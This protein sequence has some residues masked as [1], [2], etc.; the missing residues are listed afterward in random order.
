MASLKREVGIGL[1]WVAFA[2]VGM[3]GIA[4][5]RKLILAR[6]LAPND[7][8]LVAYASLAIGVLQL[9]KE[10]GFG[11]ALIYRRDDVDEAANTIFIAVLVSGCALYGLAWLLA[12][13]V[14]DFFHNPALVAILRVLASTMAISGISQVPLVLL[15]KGMGFRN[16]VIPEL[17]AGVAGSGLS[18]Y[19]AYNWFGVWSIVWGQVATTVLTAILVWFFCP[20][21]PKWQFSWRV[22]RELWD[23]ARHIIGSQILVFFI[24]NIDDAFIGRLRGDAALGTYG[25]A[26]DLSNLPAT[27]LSRI[28]GQVT[29]PA[30]SK[31]QNDLVRLRKAFFQSV[32]YV[33]L[34]AFPIA[35]ITL[36]YAKPFIIVSYGKKWTP[37]ILPLQLLAVYGLARSIAV[38][39]GNVFKVGNKPKWLLY[40]ASWRLAMM[41]LFLYPAIQWKGVVGVAALSAVVA[42]IDFC[43]SIYLTNRV[44][45]ASWRRY[46]KLF[47][48]MLVTAVISALIGHQIYTWIG[49]RIH[50]FITI[51]G[52]GGLALL[53]YGS[54]MYFYDPEIRAL[55]ADVIRIGLEAFHQWKTARGGSSV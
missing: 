54:V 29:F 21:R 41:A 43:I 12:P 9:F 37:A 33:S 36:V 52:T 1:L 47:L 31:V 38:N 2:T 4:L 17:I 32:K 10:L 26:Y 25:L 16:K 13:V 6:W 35:I 34:A 39:M 3:K 30:F 5:L 45:H 40:I 22:A 53:L 19:L 46:A 44:L 50:P 55:M 7:F 14:A 11:T 15:A 49:L 18:I 20:W 42:V 48:P 8:G 23:Y 51:P 28:V 24:T 27:H